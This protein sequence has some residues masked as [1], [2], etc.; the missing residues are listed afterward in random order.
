MSTTTGESKKKKAKN[1][2][3]E[4]LVDRTKSPPKEGVGASGEKSSKSKKDGHTV[5]PGTVTSRTS[6]LRADM[7]GSKN[8]DSIDDE[9]RPYKPIKKRPKESSDSDEESQR[10]ERSRTKSVSSDD[11][12][13]SVDSTSNGKK[14]GM[15]SPDKK[16]RKGKTDN[17][18]SSKSVTLQAVVKLM[19]LEGQLTE[20]TVR[21][22]QSFIREMRKSGHNEIKISDRVEEAMQ[23][24]LDDNF[25]A[26]KIEKDWR[27]MDDA[28]FFSHL[29]RLIN[30]SDNPVGHHADDFERM[31]EAAN[32][33]SFRFH[34]ED[35]T[36]H[37][38]FSLAIN[39]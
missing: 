11:D 35:S 12:E 20:Q 26:H 14:R 2:A 18:N 22:F 32:I 7:D 34:P 17:S 39:K 3:V 1:G 9:G 38:E 8:A 5:T 4:V 16:R 13:S 21:K 6:D 15:K 31:L 19:D 28:E 27:I 30:K 29:F 24:T 33:T 25:A 37:L 10:S 36:V 23:M